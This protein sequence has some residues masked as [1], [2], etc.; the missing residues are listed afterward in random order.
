M[1]LNKVSPQREGNTEP[2]GGGAEGVVGV[3]VAIT[4][5]PEVV[6]RGKEDVYGPQLWWF[7]LGGRLGLDLIA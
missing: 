1:F 4:L 6:V 2:W 5:C 7:S 3:V